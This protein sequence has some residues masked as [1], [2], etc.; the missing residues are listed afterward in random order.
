MARSNDKIFG[1]VLIFFGAWLF[2][3]LMGQFIIQILGSIISLWL[4]NYGLKL[5]GLPQMHY[6]IIKW[7]SSTKFK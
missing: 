7:I 1:I 6:W 5:Q 4:V 2:L 3:A